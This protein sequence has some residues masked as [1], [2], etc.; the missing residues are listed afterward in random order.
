MFATT[1]PL[2]WEVVGGTRSAKKSP[3]QK[4]QKPALKAAATATTNPANQKIEHMPP[5]KLD[6]NLYSLIN[7]DSDDEHEKQQRKR[8]EAKKPQVPNS[9]QKQKNTTNQQK[10]AATIVSKK[11]NELEAAI[12]TLNVDDFK[13]ELNNFKALYPNM[14][15]LAV[16]HMNTYLNLK[17]AAA[18]EIEPTFT[19]EDA[20]NDPLVKIDRKLKDFYQTLI[21]CLN[22]AEC[23]SLLEYLISDLL[24]ENKIQ[25]HHGFKIVLQMLIRRFPDLV[26]KRIAQFNELVTSNRHKQLKCLVYFWIIGQCG[27][28]NFLYGIKLWFEGMMRFVNIKN[29][30]SATINYLNSFLEAHSDK[31]KSGNLNKNEEIISVKQYF[32][33][34]DLINDKTANFITKDMSTKLQNSYKLIRLL[35]QNQSKAQLSNQFETILSSIPHAPSAKQTEVLECAKIALTQGKDTY[36]KWRQCYSKYLCE[37]NVLLESVKANWGFY[38]NYSLRD[39]NQT[40]KYFEQNTSLHLNSIKASSSGKHHA[41]PKSGTKS[42]SDPDNKLAQMRNFNH[43]AQTLSKERVQSFSIMRLVFRMLLVSLI[44]FGV[45]I[46]WDF[47]LNKSIYTNKIKAELDKHGLLESTQETIEA[48]SKFLIKIKNLILTYVL[49][50]YNKAKKFTIEYTSVAWKYTEEYTMY[51]WKQTESYRH[52]IYEFSLKIVDY[53]NFYA[54]TLI[55]NVASL[56]Y[57]FVNYM[58]TVGQFVLNYLSQFLNFVEVQLIGWKKGELAIIFSNGS[59]MIIESMNKFFKWLHEVGI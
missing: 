28:S 15:L 41:K 12:A 59:Q 36:S 54:P 20:S 5:L 40:I 8:A 44:M 17:L 46:Y 51:A 33:F 1:A 38:R 37:S 58:K 30:S 6:N 10:K 11:E 50:Y 35:F 25:N 26:F 48:V 9:P 18:T 39:L 21:D 34:Y 14:S 24:N 57:L 3:E 27:Y 22:K 16:R 19:A 29:F 23:D 13:Q 49:P 45:F 43:L 42:T 55:D 56:F 47:N 31:I 7:D 32:E 52:R 53:I 2:K 4:K